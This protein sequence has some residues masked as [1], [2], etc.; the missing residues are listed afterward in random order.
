MA[1]NIRDSLLPV[2]DALRQLPNSFGLRRYSVAIRSRT[3]SGNYPGELTPTDTD[4]VINPP[5]RVRNVSPE[6]VASSGGTYEAG[7]YMIEAITPSYTSLTGTTGGY[8]PAQLRIRPGAGS[9]ND[10]A[11]ILTGD[12]GSF[13][14]ELVKANFDRPFRYWLVARRIHG[15][16]RG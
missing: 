2:V 14:C 8:T 13:E 11:I 6:E 5:P 7:D 9:N 12:E 10:V 16:V 1:Q 15:A 3:W 4:T